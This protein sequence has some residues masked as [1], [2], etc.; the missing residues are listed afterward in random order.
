MIKRLFITLICLFC[1]VWLTLAQD[2][3]ELVLDEPLTVS[4]SEAESTALTFTVEDAPQ[5]VTLS[6]LAT[7]NALDP[8][9][10]ITDADNR[11]MAYNDNRDAEDMNPLIEHLYLA[12]A[13]EYT[14]YVDSFNGVTDGMAEVRV[15][16]SDPFAVQENSE[17]DPSETLI[18]V[19]LP[20]DMTY[21]YTWS[22][23]ADTTYIITVRDTSGTLDPYLTLLDSENTVLA[24][25][26]DHSTN[27][28]TLN[29]LDAQ[30][31]WQAPEDGDYTLTVHDF[32]GQTG[33]FE[34]HIQTMP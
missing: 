9:L 6:A 14:I 11:L 32:L 31:I 2:S 21:A 28:L 18:G 23:Q 15:I 1:G 17:A 24:T 5:I 16:L 4:V 8:V 22:A 13:G 25:N 27:D 33:E 7:T 19:T 10:W 26:D 12:Q 34:L 30:L 20:E 3:S 29:V